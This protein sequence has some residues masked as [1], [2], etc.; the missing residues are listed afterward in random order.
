MEKVG[1]FTNRVDGFEIV[2]ALSSSEKSK[3][4]D[5]FTFVDR[6]KVGFV[7]QISEKDHHDTSG[8]G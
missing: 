2:A 3:A 7:E 4:Q 1:T 5:K 6:T 8:G